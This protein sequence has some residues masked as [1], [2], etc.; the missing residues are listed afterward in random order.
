ML[1]HNPVMLFH[2]KDAIWSPRGLRFKNHDLVN[3]INSV[4][5]LLSATQIYITLCARV[6]GTRDFNITQTTLSAIS[7]LYFLSSRFQNAYI[8]ADVYARFQE[9]WKSKVGFSNRMSLEKSTVHQLK[10][11]IKFKDLS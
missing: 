5:I 2:I 1:F 6:D 8:Y 9:L 3:H 11:H 4:T 7:T 10:R